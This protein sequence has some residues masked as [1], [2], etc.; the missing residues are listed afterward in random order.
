MPPP[1][2]HT[3]SCT[4]IKDCLSI[5]VTSEIG[6]G[7]TGLVLGG[8]LEVEATRGCVPLGMAVKLAFTD[9]QRYS[10]REEYEVYR[11]LR[12]KGVVKGIPHAFGFFDDAEGGPSALIMSAAGSSLATL[13]RKVSR[14]DQCVNLQD[15]VLDDIDTFQTGKQLLR[16]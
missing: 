14:Y 9:D 6:R 8:Q 2:K 1:S 3:I 12:S 10:L 11:Q 4:K 7:A 5:I 15:H 16:R 13:P